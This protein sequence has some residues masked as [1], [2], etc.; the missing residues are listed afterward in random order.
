MV[1][2]A[3]QAFRAVVL[4][5]FSL[6]LAHIHFN[7]DIAKYINPKYG[8]LSQS[9]AVLFFC[10]F[11]IQ[12]FRIWGRE[13][14]HNEHFHH[15]C[16]HE[17][18]DSALK[19]VVSYSI[20]LFPLITG[21]VLPPKTLDA[22]IAAQKGTVLT[23]NAAASQEVMIGASLSD[24]EQVAVDRKEIGKDEYDKTLKD[25]NNAEIIYLKDEV[26]ETY[27][28]QINANPEKYRGRT[29]KMTGFVYKED[30]FQSNQLALTRFLVTHCIADASS[31]GFLTELDGAAKLDQDTWLEVEGK[32]EV[33]NYEGSI[34]PLL[35]VT[36]WNT[37]TEPEDPYVYPVYIK[38]M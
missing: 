22:S 18:H 1:F 32:L 25:L 14:K 12:F 38:I 35:K 13:H 8:I 17:R 20:L 29:V 19:K 23:G 10:L 30:G 28:S 5:A 7:G 36:S 6:F 33:T 31:I 16:Q 37:I 21:F 2:H 34:M 4:I 26:F 27:Y 9:A 15:G 3:Q 11:F 24:H